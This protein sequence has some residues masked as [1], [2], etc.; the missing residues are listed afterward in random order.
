M[1][2]L[3]PPTSRPSSFF[4][5]F[6]IDLAHDAIY[7][8]DAGI[9]VGFDQ[10]APALVVVYLKSGASRRVLENAECVRG[11]TSATM[12]IDGKAVEVTGPDGKSM[13]PRVGVDPIT[14]DD[15]NE[16]VYFGAMH[17]TTLW[18]V[19][20]DD[21]ASPGMYDEL[22]AERVEKAGTKP[23]CD[24]ISIDSANNVY[25]TDVTKHA[26]GVIAPDGTY[27]LFIEDPRLQWPDGMSAGPD[28]HF[29]VIANQLNRH[30]T[31]NGGLD[32][33]KPPYLLLRF[34]PLAPAT[35]GR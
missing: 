34:K 3:P 15:K 22:L 5:D 16:W 17:G 23:V 28:G 25:V 21:L 20:T 2:H 19:R 6:A 26:I 4:Q 13:S 31:L 30:A 14:I 1:I 12:T 10:P 11:E 8:A 33:T 9:G 29:Y 32:E 18:K 7:I 24:G 35:V 27:R